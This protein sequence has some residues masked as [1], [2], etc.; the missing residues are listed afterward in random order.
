MLPPNTVCINEYFDSVGIY[1]RA[2]YHKF[3]LGL[4][5]NRQRNVFAV[6]VSLTLDY[7]RL[8]YLYVNLIIPVF[9]LLQQRQSILDIYSSCVLS[10]EKGYLKR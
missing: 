7:I 3:S 10:K 1:H 4:P 8:D 9:Y 2:N 5:N 6:P